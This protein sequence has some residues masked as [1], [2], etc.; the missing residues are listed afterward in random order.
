MAEK[1]QKIAIGRWV[2]LGVLILFTM[3]YFKRGG[4]FGG[5]A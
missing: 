2:F 5:S 3:W 4:T 1:K